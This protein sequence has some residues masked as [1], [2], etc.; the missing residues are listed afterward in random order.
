MN[1]GCLLAA[2]SGDELPLIN[3]SVDG[4][5]RW[6][7]A[8]EVLVVIATE[9]RFHRKEVLVLAG[10]QLFWSAEQCVREETKQL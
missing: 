4:T 7:R 8:G 9:D 10:G 2:M 1:P 5:S 3:A 6:A